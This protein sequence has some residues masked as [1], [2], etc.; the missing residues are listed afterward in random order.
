MLRAVTSPLDRQRLL[1]Q[2]RRIGRQQWARPPQVQQPSKQQQC[3]AHL[4]RL[5]DPTAY[6][7]SGAFPDDNKGSPNCGMGVDSSLAAECQH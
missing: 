1:A 7:V 6:L 2:H 5:A 4:L 3:S